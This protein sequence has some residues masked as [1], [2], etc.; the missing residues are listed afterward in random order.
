MNHPTQVQEYS[1]RCG[2]RSSKNNIEIAQ[3]I[4]EAKYRT[5]MGRDILFSERLDI[6]HF[7]EELQT[8]DLGAA[9]NAVMAC[10]H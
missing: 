2:L 10:A 1:A 5:L 4:A 3:Q 7:I 8:L 6:R 9:K